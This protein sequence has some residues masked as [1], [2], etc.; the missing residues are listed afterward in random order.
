MR[1]YGQATPPKY[2]LSLVDFPVAAFGGENDILAPPKD[3]DW[4]VK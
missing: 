2:D 4:T 1:H 3:V